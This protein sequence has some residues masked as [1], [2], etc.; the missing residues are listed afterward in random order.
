MV[1]K[2]GHPERTHLLHANVNEE[3][4]G[5]HKKEFQQAKQPILPHQGVIGCLGIWEVFVSHLKLYRLFY[6]V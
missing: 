4:Y 3:G 6:L 1:I 2:K 5:L